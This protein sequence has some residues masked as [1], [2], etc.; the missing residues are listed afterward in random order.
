MQKE[1]VR[2]PTARAKDE[3]DRPALNDARTVLTA[4]AARPEA[5]EGAE[6]IQEYAEA[7]LGVKRGRAR[8]VSLADR[9]AELLITDLVYLRWVLSP[10][11]GCIRNV[12]DA[13][14]VLS[15]AVER[16]LRWPPANDNG[17]AP[18]G[19]AW[20]A[21]KFARKDFFRNVRR[22]QRLATAL[23]NREHGERR[24]R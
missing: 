23:E 4:P 14:D 12:A 16:I 21:L 24:D 7:G 20:A 8:S 2:P 18:E 10:R 5:R 13:H 3:P 1:R 19:A 15:D 6:T 22:R 11:G 17:V 9:A